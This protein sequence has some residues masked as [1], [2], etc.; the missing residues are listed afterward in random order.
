MF[1]SCGCVWSDW[2]KNTHNMLMR[3]CCGFLWRNT[4]FVLLIDQTVKYSCH[5]RR[6]TFA[7]ASYYDHEDKL[8]LTLSTSSSP[9]HPGNFFPRMRIV[10]RTV[11]LMF[12]VDRYGTSSHFNYTVCLP[13][14]QYW[15]FDI[16][17]CNVFTIILYP[18]TS[19]DYIMPGRFC[20]FGICLILNTGRTV[21]ALCRCFTPDCTRIRIRTTFRATHF[22]LPL[23][24][25]SS[26]HA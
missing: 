21:D 23:G 14:Y 20:S 9:L 10:Q 15:L 22:P 6:K 18:L 2:K 11:L 7:L 3:C 12:Q 8:S 19:S 4:H 1:S 26:L 13:F 25:A 5:I 24:S 16:F 17:L